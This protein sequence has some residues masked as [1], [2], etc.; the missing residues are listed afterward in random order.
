MA[1]IIGVQELQHTNGTTA[2]TIDSSGQVL[3]PAIPFMKMEVSGNTSVGS[4]SDTVHTTPFSNVLSS[5]G[6]T[7]NTSTYMFQVPVTGLYHFSGAVRINAL[8]DYIWWTIADSSDTRLQTSAFVLG[9]YRSPVSQFSTS[10]GS[11][12]MP[13]TASTDYQIQ[14]GSSVAG[15]VT[16]NANQTWMDIFLVGGN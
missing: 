7:L 3:L 16:V 8:A 12:L 5:R 2:A 9:N 1:S 10:S 4:G 15:A 6:I 13:L 14:F 11:Q